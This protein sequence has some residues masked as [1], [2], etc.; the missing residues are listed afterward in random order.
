M[1]YEVQND[2]I[3]HARDQSFVQQILSKSVHCLAPIGGDYCLSF[4]VHGVSQSDNGI[5]WDLL[6]YHLKGYC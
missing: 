1:R 4:S 3:E 2:C 6:P 5:H